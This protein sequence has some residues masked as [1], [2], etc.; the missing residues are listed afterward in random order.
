MI[1]LGVHDIIMGIKPVEKGKLFHVVS[2]K[3]IDFPSLADA[4]FAF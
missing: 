2:A 4:Q 3:M 1:I